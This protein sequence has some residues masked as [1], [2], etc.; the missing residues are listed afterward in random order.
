MSE[1]ETEPTTRGDD[2]AGVLGR[3]TPPGQRR[4]AGDGAGVPG[5]GDH[6]GAAGA[7]VA[8]GDALS[9][10]L[11]VPWLVAGAAGLLATTSARPAPWRGP[12]TALAG[13]PAGRRSGR[14]GRDDEVGVVGDQAVHPEVQQQ[15]G[16]A[17]EVA[18]RL[19]AAVGRRQVRR[20][21]AQG[22][23][24][25]RQPLAVGVAH[26]VGRPPSARP[27]RGRPGCAGHRCRR[28]TA[29]SARP[30][31]EARS[32][33]VRGSPRATRSAGAVEAPSS[34]TSGTRST[35]A[36]ACAAPRLEGHHADAGA[37]VVEAV[38][39][40]VVDQRLDS[41]DRPRA[42]DQ[43][44]SLS[45]TR[46]PMLRPRAADSSATM[47]STS[48][49]VGTGCRPSWAA[50]PGRSPGRRS[51]ALRRRTSLEGEVVGEPARD[52][53]TVDDLGGAQVRRARGAPRRRW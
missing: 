34:W 3:G 31:G 1:H 19:L 12:L 15:R 6:L 39:A 36:S 24:V 44:A 26:Q 42:A 53:A 33:K 9:W 48:S 52:L 51:R 18:V 4:A 38:A 46:T 17:G 40:Q 20:L 22:P 21:R 41:S 11:P 30:A 27:R 14:H 5:P 16:V 25:H 49:K 2:R 29:R 7:D 47:V 8:D 10:L 23:H 28:R 13:S 50:E 37:G 35:G 45:S 32:A 43:A